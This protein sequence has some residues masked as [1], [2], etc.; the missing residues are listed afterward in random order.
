MKKALWATGVA[1]ILWALTA[2]FIW[3]DPFHIRD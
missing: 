1:L 2:I 3:I